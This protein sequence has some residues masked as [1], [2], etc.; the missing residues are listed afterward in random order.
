MEIT[1]GFSLLFSL[2]LAGG[3]WAARRRP[4]APLHVDCAALAGFASLWWFTTAMTATLRGAQASGEGLPQG[5]ARGAVIALSWLQLLAFVAAWAA[6]TWSRLTHARARSL[7]AKEAAAAAA[8]AVA[9]ADAALAKGSS[10]QRA[11]GLPP[12]APPAAT[13]TVTVF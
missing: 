1:C 13:V 6:V 10:G 9:E 12:L 3:W 7:A 8:E 4:D 2:L 5:G 11:H